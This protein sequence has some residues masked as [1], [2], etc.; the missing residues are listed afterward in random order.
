RVDA[1]AETRLRLELESIGVLNEAALEAA[2]VQGVM[3]LA[4]KTVHL[5]VGLN[6]DQ[7]AAEMQGQLAGNG[8]PG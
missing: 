2:G 5:L 6:A 3:R 4:D 7:Y 8:G 1:C